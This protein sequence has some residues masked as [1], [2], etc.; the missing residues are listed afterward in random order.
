MRNAYRIFLLYMQG[1][2]FGR[3]VRRVCDNMKTV[4]KEVWY[5]CFVYCVY[6]AVGRTSTEYLQRQ[7]NVSLLKKKIPTRQE[8]YV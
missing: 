6:L 3:P 4:V 2:T 8:I 1:E 5:V 7:R